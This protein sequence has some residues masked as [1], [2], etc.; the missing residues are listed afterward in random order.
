M[1]QFGQGAG[2]GGNGGHT[3]RPCEIKLGPLSGTWYIFLST[4]C[5]AEF[6]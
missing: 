4:L 1:I 2:G 3:E 6:S 5:N